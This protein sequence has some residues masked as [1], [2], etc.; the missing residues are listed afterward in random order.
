[1][2]SRRMGLLPRTALH[3]DSEQ[4]VEGD[5]E[6]I[7]HMLCPTFIIFYCCSSTHI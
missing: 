1:M 3:S 5:N 2:S 7:I 6:I 4:L